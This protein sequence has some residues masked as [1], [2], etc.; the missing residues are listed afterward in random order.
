M[1]GLRLNQFGSRPARGG[2]LAGFLP[3]RLPADGTLV[4]RGR[5]G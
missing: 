5:P 1:E 4:E 2:H 3:G